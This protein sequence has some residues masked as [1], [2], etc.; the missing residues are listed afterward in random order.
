MNSLLA[1]ILM[2]NIWG[3]AATQFT[4][5]AF[6]DYLRMTAIE[7]IFAL[8]INNLWFFRIFLKYYIFYAIMGA[9]GLI[10]IVLTIKKRH[11]SSKKQDGL[12]LGERLL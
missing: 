8:Q 1:N 5:I 9:A 11:F 2:A 4:A 10:G 6:Q 7:N 3:L 12:L